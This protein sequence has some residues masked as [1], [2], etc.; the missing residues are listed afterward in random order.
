MNLPGA[1]INYGKNYTKKKPIMPITCPLCGKPMVKPEN[2]LGHE[3]SVE[4]DNGSSMEWFDGIKGWYRCS[5]GTC[6]MVVYLS[7]DPD[8]YKRNKQ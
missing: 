6:P 7:D 5:S 2:V 8:Q 1:R 4:Y 3:I